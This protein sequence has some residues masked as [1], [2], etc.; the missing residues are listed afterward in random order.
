[1]AF[2]Y[3]SGVERQRAYRRR[4]AQARIDVG[5]VSGVLNMETGRVQ[6]QRVWRRRKLLNSLN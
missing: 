3:S 5:L 2:K 1:L 6:R 4:K